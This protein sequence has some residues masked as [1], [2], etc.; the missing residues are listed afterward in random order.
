MPRGT[1]VYVHCI[2]IL[3][4]QSSPPEF[5]LL[6]IYGLS[7]VVL[8]DSVH[9][10]EFDPPFSKYVYNSVALPQNASSLCKRPYSFASFLAILD[11]EHRRLVVCNASQEYKNDGPESFS[12]HKRFA[13]S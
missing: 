3:L 13:S 4:S 2:L 5:V 11:L 8:R 9:S 1:M 6:T 7:V 10:R 12:P